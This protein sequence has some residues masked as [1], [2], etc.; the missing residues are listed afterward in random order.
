MEIY[1]SLGQL[2][3]EMNPTNDPFTLYVFPTSFAFVFITSNSSQNG[4]SSIY[5][6]SITLNIDTPS[7][8]T[9]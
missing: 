4:D 6:F 5:D 1:D 7:G 8:T 2:S 9:L 3:Y